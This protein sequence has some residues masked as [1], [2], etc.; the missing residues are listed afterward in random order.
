[1]SL[2]L[3]PAGPVSEAI[4]APSK[5]QLFVCLASQD[6]SATPAAAPAAG[7][8]LGDRRRLGRRRRRVRPARQ[9]HSK[10][11]MTADAR[12]AGQGSTNYSGARRAVSCAQKITTALARM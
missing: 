8:A 4:I 6:H 11:P 7:P 10:V 9:V 12:P 2:G 3:Q 5:M 1:M